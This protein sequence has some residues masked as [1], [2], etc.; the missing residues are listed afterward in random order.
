MRRAIYFCTATAV[1]PQCDGTNPAWYARAYIA[2]NVSGHGPAIS[3]YLNGLGTEAQAFA[4]PPVSTTDACIAAE[5]VRGNAGVRPLDMVDQRYLNM[6][7][8]ISCVPP[9]SRSL[10]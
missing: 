5:Q 10:R 3:D 6:I 2:G 7:P 9:P 1:A 8:L 4:A